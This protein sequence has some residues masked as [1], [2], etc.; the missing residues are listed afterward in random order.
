[1]AIFFLF[2]APASL[3]DRCGELEEPV[4]MHTSSVLRSTL[5]D[6]VVYQE[7]FESNGK[8]YM[9][10]VTA[11]ESSWI[12]SFCKSMCNVGKPLDDPPPYFDEG[13]GI[14]MC[15]VKS[16]YGKQGWELPVHETEFPYSLEKFKIF[17]QFLL[18]GDIFPKL[19]EW[20]SDLL[21]LPVTMTKPWA[22]LQPRTQKLLNALT[23]KKICTKSGLLDRWSRDKNYL[24]EEY[25]EW[26][27]PKHHV[28]VTCHWP[29]LS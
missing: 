28:Q 22:K 23:S 12:P 15:F 2:W 7:I 3:F 4:I 21:S 16:T 13:K 18:Q 8:M 5:P 24:L 10:G 14:I 20:R 1:M 19:A 25:L 27:A 9:R 29:P 6:W 17:A 26:L 11:I